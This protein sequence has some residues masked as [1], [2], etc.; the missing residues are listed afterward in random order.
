MSV[1]PVGGRGGITGGINALLSHLSS[2]KVGPQGTSGGRPP[3]DGLEPLPARSSP[4]KSFQDRFYQDS[5]ESGPRRQGGRGGG[6]DLTGQG[7]GGG[8]QARASAGQDPE[9][10]LK[11][12]D[13]KGQK[14]RSPVEVT[15]FPKGQQP[16]QRSEQQAGEKGARSQGQD[17]KDQF[18][19]AD[20]EK[21]DPAAQASKD[22]Q[23]GQAS[24]K[25]P[26]QKP[27][28]MPKPKPKKPPMV[29][30]P[31]PS[32][33]SAFKQVTVGGEVKVE[34]RSMSERKVESP[35]GN[36]LSGDGGAGAAAQQMVALAQKM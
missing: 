12:G 1:G 4:Q 35:Q 34:R 5:F 6:L 9:A 28:M 29:K 25:A 14:K 22:R 15:E 30:P 33:G 19:P 27:V 20:Q 31:V 11:T 16:R 17:Q 32:L 2:S 24:K 26:P 36:L 10:L 13:Q 7:R 23:A 8:Q 21:A 3:I 18:E